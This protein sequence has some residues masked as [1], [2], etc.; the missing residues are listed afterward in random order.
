[1]SVSKLTSKGQATIPADIRAALGVK[2][3]D[4]VEFV[5]NDAGEMVVRKAPSLAD[6]SGMMKVDPKVA[7]ELAGKSW[8]QIRAETWD[9][10][11]RDRHLDRD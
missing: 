4:S 2:P 7:A 9:D 11:I 5:M 3:G 1:M 10:V 8:D 6:L